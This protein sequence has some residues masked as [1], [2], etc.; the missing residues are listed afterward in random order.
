M[1]KTPIYPDENLV[2]LAQLVAYLEQDPEARKDFAR[3]PKAFLGRIGLKESTVETGHGHDALAKARKALDT[4]GLKEH[5]TLISALPKLSKAAGEL[6][7]ADYRVDIEPFAISFLERPRISGFR[8]TITG[9]IRCTFDGWD[10][11][12]IGLD[13]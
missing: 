6:F 13:W 12:S 2:S 1:S 8:W 3:D 4:A 9:R 7:G 5:E 11:C 10:G